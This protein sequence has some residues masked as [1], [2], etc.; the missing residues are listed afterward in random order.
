VADRTLAILSWADVA[1]A[2]ADGGLVVVDTLYDPRQGLVFDGGTP[3]AGPP[4][5]GDAGGGGNPGGGGGGPLGPGI[6]VDHGS[7]SCATAGTGSTLVA[8]LGL[9]AFSV[10]LRRRRSG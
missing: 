4:D 6:P 1:D 7:S 5:A 9:L 8:L 3:D 2:G 10:L